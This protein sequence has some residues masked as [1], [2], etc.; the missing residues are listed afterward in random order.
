MTNTPMTTCPNCGGR[1]HTIRSWEEGSRT[2]YEVGCDTCGATF[3]ETEYHSELEIDEFDYGEEHDSN[4]YQEAGTYYDEFDALGYTE[5][6]L[7]EHERFFG[8]D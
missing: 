1:I 4:H 2:E 3:R 8:P 5:T 6:G 7:A